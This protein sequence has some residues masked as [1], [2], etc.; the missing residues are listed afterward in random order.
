MTI[1]SLQRLHLRMQGKPVDHAPNFDIIMAYGAHYIGATM[2]SYLLDYRTLVQMNLAMIEDFHLDIA[3]TLSDPFRESVDWGLEVEF[4]E[5]GLPKR[6]RPLLESPDDLQKLKPPLSTAG[7][8]MND[9]LEAVRLLKEQLGDTVP[10]MGWVEGALAEA[11]DLR[12]DSALL[13]DL[14]DRPEWLCE[15]LELLTETEIAFAR[16]QIEAGAHIIGLG[17]AIAS[18]VSPKMY[19]TF[20]LPYEQRIFAA[21]K[22]M[23]AL[24]RLHICGNTSKIVPFMAD[25]GADIIDVDWMVDYG[26]AAKV[27]AEHPNHPVLCGNFDPV[28]IML[29]G[30]PEEVYAA[31][32]QN[33]LAGGNRCISATGCEI[34]LD[35]PVENIHAQNRALNDFELQKN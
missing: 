13:M 4:P 19:K 21:I 6:L 14:Y 15:V 18:T 35:T 12:G 2:R 27:F 3:Q 11:N 5:D 34:P 26:M 33:L 28:R 7:G 23:G 20:A 32:W 16:I 1:T 22:S 17:D 25:S 10:I 9:R 30:T 24:G 31:T 29:Q 8:R